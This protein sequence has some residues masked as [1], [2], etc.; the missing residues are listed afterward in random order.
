MDNSKP[1]KGKIK[2]IASEEKN[3]TV[4]L[5]PGMKLEVIAVDLVEP[6]LKASKKVAARLC[7]GS[8]TCVALVEI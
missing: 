2:F 8:R 1:T 5:K 7:G 3:P 6:T 4:K